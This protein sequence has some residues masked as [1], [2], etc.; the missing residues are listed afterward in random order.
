MSITMKS[1]EHFANDSHANVLC[2]LLI[3]LFQKRN[4]LSTPLISHHHHSERG[5]RERTGRRGSLETRLKESAYLKN[6]GSIFKV[7]E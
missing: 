3:L 1:E 4:T 7:G 6:G 2:F 5:K